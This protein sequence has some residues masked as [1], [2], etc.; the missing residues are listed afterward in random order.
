M[1]NNILF[2]ILIGI[3]L[4]ILHIPSI[5]ITL[6]IIGGLSCLSIMLFWRVLLMFSSSAP[7]SKT[8]GAAR[9]A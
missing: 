1:T 5:M 7:A 3:A 8:A 9:G 4:A 6:I 2:L